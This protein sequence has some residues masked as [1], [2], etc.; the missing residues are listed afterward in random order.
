MKEEDN[1]QSHSRK[2]RQER[3]QPYERILISIPTGL[4]EMVDEAAEKDFTTRS[5]V[6]RAAVLWYLRP[7]GRDL[8]QADPEV[9]LKVLQ[10]RKS[11]IALRHLVRKA[12]ATDD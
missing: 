3:K 5:D 8:D 7:Q 9:I 11:Q 4:L 1:P 6:I 2:K 10:H 12:K